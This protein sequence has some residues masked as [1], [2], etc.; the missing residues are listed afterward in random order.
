VNLVTNPGYESGTNSFFSNNGAN[1]PVT[2]DTVAPIG[3]TRS[4]YVVRAGT[5]NTT[6]ASGY[7]APTINT[8]KFS[9]TE[10]QPITYGYSVKTDTP[11]LTVN[12]KWNWYD[13]GSVQIPAPT[14]VQVASTVAGQIYRVSEVGIPPVGAVTAWPQLLVTK[15]TIAV[16]GEKIWYDYATVENGTTDGSWF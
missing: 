12:T 13:S 16:G 9:V 14:N 3:G 4:A 2:A 8:S 10:G 15:A 5:M 6:V 11:G 1:Y 7:I